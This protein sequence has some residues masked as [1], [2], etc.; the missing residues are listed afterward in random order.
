MRPYR[1][2]QGYVVEQMG[3]KLYVDPIL[4]CLIRHHVGEGDDAETVRLTEGLL[5]FVSLRIERE[6]L[7]VVLGMLPNPLPFAA[8]NLGART[9]RLANGVVRTSC[10]TLLAPGVFWDG[11]SLKCENSI[12][13]ESVRTIARGMP[14]GDL[15]G[16][17]YLPIDL[18]LSSI[19]QGKTHW[20]ANF[21][22]PRR[23]VA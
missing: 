19:S 17:P 21:K 8:V 3:P 11:R 18:P 5:S 13:P 16:H 1:N 2:L 12:L 4:S 7:D 20:I 14:L 9:D 10:S 6:H 23:Q 15:V 22:V